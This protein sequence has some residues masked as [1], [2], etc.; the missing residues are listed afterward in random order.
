MGAQ[1]SGA[2]TSFA[3]SRER[4][5]RASPS[6]AFGSSREDPRGAV[7]SRADLIP[8]CCWS[9]QSPI[10]GCAV[11]RSC[12]LGNPAASVPRLP[13][14]EGQSR[15]AVGRA[16]QTR[17]SGGSTMAVAVRAAGCLSA[18]CGAPAGESRDAGRGLRAG[19]G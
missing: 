12:G 4:T 3:H 9:G 6:P 11:A 13:C 14:D 10:P 5:P 7:R 17:G 2:P 15:Q 8:L 18:L 19:P 16:A 1:R